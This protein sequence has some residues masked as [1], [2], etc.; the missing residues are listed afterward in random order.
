LLSFRVHHKK[1]SPC[2]CI[3]DCWSFRVC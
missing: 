2:T 1:L 3:G